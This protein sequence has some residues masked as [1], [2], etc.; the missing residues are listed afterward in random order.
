MSGSSPAF[1]IC[2]DT[3]NP[4]S[5]G[6]GPEE[7]AR[8][9]APLIKHLHLKDYTIHFAPE[10]YRLVR[11]AAGDG[12]IDFASILDAVKDNGFPDLLPGCEIAAQATRTIPLLEASWWDCYPERSAAA[13]IPAL[14]ILWQY[15]RPMDEPY[16]SAWERG[17]DSDVVCAEEWKVLRRSVEYFRGLYQEVK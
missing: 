8:K 7:T 6:E 9:L 14:R 4:L 15:G 12:C 5:V 17:E 16:S 11:C 1:G 10:G 2:L 3:G 13:L